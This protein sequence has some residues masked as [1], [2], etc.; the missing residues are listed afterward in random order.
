MQSMETGSKKNRR[1]INSAGDEQ[2]NEDHLRQVPQT[3]RPIEIMLVED[4]PGDVRLTIEALKEGKVINHLQVARDGQEAMD[5][6]YRK[7]EYANA[8]RPDI[9]LL[10]LNLPKKDGREVLAEIKADVGLRAIPVVVLTMSKAEEDILKT[11]QHYA[12]CYITKPIAMD[13]FLKTMNQI[14]NFWL[15]IVKLPPRINNDEP[16]KDR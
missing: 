16:N 13:Q 6:L 1:E 14:E 12:N 2:K 10:D 4:S 8:L 11:Y 5:M 15:S 3:G 7:G 9:I